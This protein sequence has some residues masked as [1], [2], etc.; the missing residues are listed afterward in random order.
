MAHKN[1]PSE[2]QDKTVAPSDWLTPGRTFQKRAAIFAVLASLIWPVQAGLVAFALG[3]LL[4]GAHVSPALIAL[5]FVSL[6]CGARL[7]WAQVR[8]A[9]GNRCA[10]CGGRCTRAYCRARS[11]SAHRIAP[12]GGAGS[13]SAL[14]GAKLD[15]LTPY[16]TRYASARARV[17]VVPIVIFALSLVV[18][19]GGRSG[20]SSYRTFDSGV[21]GAD[22]DGRQRCQPAPDG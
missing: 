11:T 13:I 4:T 6:R 12:F 19:M 15:H 2:A 10:V 7:A 22:W 14:A 3:G 20:P 8:S 17:M 21:H 18:V 9:G 1:G 5:G 16:I